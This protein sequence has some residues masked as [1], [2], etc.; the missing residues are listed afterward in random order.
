M[1]SD[2]CNLVLKKN[3]ERMF[4][5]FEYSLRSSALRHKTD[6]KI[7]ECLHNLCNALL[8]DPVCIDFSK[9]LLWPQEPIC[10]SSF[11]RPAGRGSSGKH[12]P[13]NTLTLKEREA[14]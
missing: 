9:R 1:K 11:F 14:R 6:V 7:N 8:P 13:E 2:V 3:G 12:Q 5:T 10:L 4:W